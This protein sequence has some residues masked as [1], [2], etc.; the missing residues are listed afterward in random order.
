MQSALRLAPTPPYRSQC[1]LAYA[2]IRSPALSH[3]GRNRHYTRR[4]SHKPHRLLQNL[5]GPS[6]SDG[7]LPP[8]SRPPRIQESAAASTRRCLLIRREFSNRPDLP[9]PPALSPATHC[10]PAWAVPP[11]RVP[12]RLRSHNAR[13]ALLSY[14]SPSVSAQSALF[15]TISV[16]PMVKQQ[17]HAA[18]PKYQLH[19]K[20]R[21]CE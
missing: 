4:D 11:P 10:L 3:T 8:L 5:S 1:A 13:C 16:S 19:S 18:M 2:R 12:I 17:F 20:Q 9:L 7:R 6:G 14:F 15:N 21:C